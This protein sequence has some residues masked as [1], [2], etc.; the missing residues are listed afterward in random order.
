MS[1]FQTI[2]INDDPLRKITGQ[3]KKKKKK[4]TKIIMYAHKFLAL[5]LSSVKNKIKLKFL[6]ILNYIYR[7]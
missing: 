6:N 7:L 5:Y 3:K 1:E 4:K 2:L